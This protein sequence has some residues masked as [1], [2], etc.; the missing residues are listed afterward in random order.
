MRQ[1]KVGGWE[2]TGGPRWPRKAPREWGAARLGRDSRRPSSPSPPP[3]DS[4]PFALLSSQW[5]AWKPTPA[6]E[7]VKERGRRSAQPRRL[8][9]G[10]IQRLLCPEVAACVLRFALRRVAAHDPPHG[11][12]HPGLLSRNWARLLCKGS[13]PSGMQPPIQAR[14]IG[15]LLPLPSTASRPAVGMSS[16][17]SSRGSSPSEADSRDCPPEAAGS[18]KA[19]AAGPGQLYLR[20]MLR[21]TNFYFCLEISPALLK[22]PPRGQRGSSAEGKLPVYHLITRPPKCLPCAFQQI[23]PWG[24]AQGPHFPARP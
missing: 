23:P 6:C 12:P 11:L 24:S 1:E 13:P 5:T 14:R 21:G 9:W 18:G 4:G 15:K 16:L 22:N 7:R 2:K 3:G 17:H 10:R 20:G 19:R 8:R